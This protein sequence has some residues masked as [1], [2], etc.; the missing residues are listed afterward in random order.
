M[1]FE[2]FKT[3]SS[4]HSETEPLHVDVNVAQWTVTC[5][6]GNKRIAK[7][8]GS[9]VRVRLGVGAGAG[10]GVGGCRRGTGWYHI[11]YRRTL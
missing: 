8:S 5:E 4:G 1:L 7:R 10:V 11:L 3:L 6:E 9:E 2:M